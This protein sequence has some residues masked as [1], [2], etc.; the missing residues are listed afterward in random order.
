MSD[1]T[2]SIKTKISPHYVRQ[3]HIA[4]LCDHN[5]DK[6]SF[7][8]TIYSRKRTNNIIYNCIEVKYDPDD[9]FWTMEALRNDSLVKFVES[10]ILRY[11]PSIH[12]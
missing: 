4:L 12:S 6:D 10:A 3:L 11:V 8:V 2:C 7:E 5:L 9:H 1:L